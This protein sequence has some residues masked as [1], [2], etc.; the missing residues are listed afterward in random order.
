MLYTKF[1]LYYRTLTLTGTWANRDAELSVSVYVCARLCVFRYTAF[2]Y[3]I[4]SSAQDRRFSEPW[5]RERRSSLEDL[6][7][8]WPT[9]A[10]ATLVNLWPALAFSLHWRRSSQAGSVKASPDHCRLEIWNAVGYTTARW[11]GPSPSNPP[12]DQRSLKPILFLPSHIS[13]LDTTFREKHWEW[14]QSE[15][16][17]RFSQREWVA[18]KGTI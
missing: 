11:Q 15:M 12:G 2:K 9:A 5:F 18:L 8:P 7:K 13:Y 14:S 1:W 16:L 6:L 17:K 3:Y 10:L 4:I